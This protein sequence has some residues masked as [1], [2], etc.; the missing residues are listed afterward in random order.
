MWFSL[1]SKS[2]FVL[3]TDIFFPSNLFVS[4]N[5]G[6]ICSIF[7]YPMLQLFFSIC[8]VQDV[9][10]VKISFFHPTY[11][12]FTNFEYFGECVQYETSN[13]ERVTHHSKF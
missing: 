7:V 6:N 3:F 4:E 12:Y 9:V 13:S 11:V 5:K 2:T 1:R 8:T 10:T